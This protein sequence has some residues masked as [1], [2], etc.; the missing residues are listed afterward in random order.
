[1]K[2]RLV[3]ILLLSA[4]LVTYSQINVTGRGG[5]TVFPGKDGFIFSVSPTVLLNTPNGQ[6]FAGGFKAQYFLGR[7][8]SIDADLV[9]SRDYIHFS[10]G[11][12]VIPLSMIILNSSDD[13]TFNEVLGAIVALALSLEHIS[14]HIPV[15]EK[16]D[17][18]P[19]VS[20]LRYKSAYEF[21]NYSDMNHIAEQFSF[22]GGVQLNRY[23]GRF[24]FSPYAEYCIGYQDHISGF[25]AGVY[26]GMVF[27]GK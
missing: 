6:Q 21:G 26:F 13:Y 11:L 8:F 16:S 12:I 7:R 23:A 2:K 5:N 14:Y 4:S 24:V 27:P 25:N 9:F 22:A 3:L 18:S 10:P 15:T 1:M 20:L 17:I 19:F